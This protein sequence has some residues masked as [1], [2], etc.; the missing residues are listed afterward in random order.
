[1]VGSAC[2][3]FARYGLVSQLLSHTFCLGFQLVQYDKHCCVFLERMR[4]SSSFDIVQ[5]FKSFTNEFV[6][7]HHSSAEQCSEAIHTFIEVRE[8]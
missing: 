3:A 6:G 7:T 8:D 1:M 5:K 4:Q 2:R